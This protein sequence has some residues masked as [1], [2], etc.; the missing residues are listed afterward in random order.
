MALI[1]CPECG[2]ENIS[3]T[4]DA[5]PDCGYSFKS[6]KRQKKRLVFLGII[7]VIILVFFVKGAISNNKQ[8]QIDNL[9]SKTD[10]YYAEMNLTAVEECC[11]SLDELGY[12]TSEI[13]EKIEYDIQNYDVA[14]QFHEALETANSKLDIDTIDT[15]AEEEFLA[16]LE[17]MNDIT[18][19]FS[20][21]GVANVNRD[22]KVGQ[23]YREM[24][25]NVLFDT[26]W[27]EVLVKRVTVAY[28]NTVSNA[29]QVKV[30]LEELLE[31]EFPYMKE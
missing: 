16:I 3:S 10:G 4:A 19:E 12:D 1:K 26:L 13:R 8:K 21:T 5:C 18:Q 31:I 22:S 29:I 15:I 24:C 9:L 20:I 23:Y 17:E 11:N 2:R 14:L 25:D 7:L 30:I 6:K 28:N 27:D